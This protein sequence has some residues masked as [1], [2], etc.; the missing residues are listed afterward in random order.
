MQLEKK[1]GMKM[2]LIFEERAEFFGSFPSQKITVSEKIKYIKYTKCFLTR[3]K[4][5]KNKISISS[6]WSARIWDSENRKRIKKTWTPCSI[7]EYKRRAAG[8]DGRCRDCGF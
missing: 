6:G 5:Y 8:C 7:L 1:K 4:K 2:C 3:R